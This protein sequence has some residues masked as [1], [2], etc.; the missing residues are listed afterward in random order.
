[1]LMSSVHK[2]MF[3]NSFT[4][5]TDHLNE[6]WIRPTNTSSTERLCTGPKKHWIPCLK[7][8][9]HKWHKIKA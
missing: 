6:M 3:D 9:N 2:G 5:I 7:Q 8:K 4:A 1:M